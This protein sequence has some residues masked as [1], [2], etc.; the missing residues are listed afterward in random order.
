[1]V[2]FSF[3]GSVLACSAGVSPYS[4]PSFFSY[5]LAFSSSS[6][7]LVKNSLFSSRVLMV[8]SSCVVVIGTGTLIL[9]KYEIVSNPWFKVF[10]ASYY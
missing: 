4:S 7:N 5:C 8:Y 10:L 9:S 1:L 3:F 2:L 6:G